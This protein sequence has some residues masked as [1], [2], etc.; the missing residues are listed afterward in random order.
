M[1]DGTESDIFPLKTALGYYLISIDTRSFESE[2]IPLRSSDLHLNVTGI[3]NATMGISLAAVPGES[4]LANGL[5]V[6]DITLTHPLAN[7][8]QFSGFDV[9]GI[10]MTKG[11][12]DVGP[13]KFAGTSDTRLLN[14]DG[15]TRWWNPAEFTSPGMFGY[16]QGNLSPTPASILTAT[17]NPYKY[18]A[19]ALSPT[20]TMSAVQ[21]APLDADNGRGIFSSGA[22]NTRRYQIQ[23]EMNPGPKVQFGYAIGASWLLPDPNPPNEVPDDFPINA[24]QPEAYNIAIADKANSLFYD[25]ESGI[26]GGVLRLQ[27]NVQDWQ[28]QQ[29]GNIAGQVEAVRL[30]SPD[31]Y[32]GGFNATFKEETSTKAVYTLDLNGTALPTHSG[33]TQIFVRAASLGGPN[34]QQGFGPAP[35]ANIDAWNVLTLNIPDPDCVA[36]TTDAFNEAITIGLDAPYIDQMCAPNDYR[37][38]YKFTIQ[39]GLIYDGTLTLYCDVEPTTFGIYDSDEQLIHE[40]MVSNGFAI[41]NFNDLNLFPELYYIRI[42]TNSNDIAFKYMLDPDF[43]ITDKYPDN[44]TNLA[45]SEIGMNPE[46]IRIYQDNMYVIGANQLWIY[47][48]S[49]PSDPVLVSSTIIDGYTVKPA[50]RYPNIYYFN[51][52]E[53]VTGEV[54]LIDV[55]DPANPVDY[56]S[57]FSLPYFANAFSMDEKYLYLVWYDTGSTKYHLDLYDYSIDPQNPEWQFAFIMDLYIAQTDSIKVGDERFLVLNTGEL[58]QTINI[59]DLDNIPPPDEFSWV[60]NFSTGMTVKDNFIFCT[61]EDINTTDDWLTILERKSQAQGLGTIT[62]YSLQPGDYQYIYVT[63]DTA[64]IPDITGHLNLY[65]ITDFQFPL[66]SGMLN[67]GD[68]VTSIAFSGSYMY[69]GYL[70]KGIEAIDFT[71]PLS[72]VSS[73]KITGIDSPVDA[74]YH[75]GYIYSLEWSYNSRMVKSFQVTAPDQI[76]YLDMINIQEDP[77]HMAVLDDKLIIGSWNNKTVLAVDISD[78]ANLNVVDSKTYGFNVGAIAIDEKYIYVSTAEDKVY[79]LQTSNW[80]VLDGNQYLANV[81]VAS[82][83]LID[84][85]VVY[86]STGSTLKVYNL[87]LGTIFFIED[88]EAM[89]YISN[90]TLNDDYMLLSTGNGLEVLDRTNPLNVDLLGSIDGPYAPIGYN[91]AADNQF[92][93]VTSNTPWSNLYLFQYLPPDNPTFIGPVLSDNLTHVSTK[94]FVM[95]EMLFDFNSSYG[96]LI[97]DL[98]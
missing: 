97:W 86:I 27:V 12:V 35:D 79:L 4:D 75:D 29:A 90:L 89:D 3:L 26:G 82:D 14:A 16:T 66:Y 2:I 95:D 41:M 8:P 53:N 38:F 11:S 37:D 46:D 62:T 77:T 48:I 94:L 78:P 61:F 74:L 10:L 54:G 30:F 96:L 81:P 71:T 21:N 69:A 25:S 64:V 76:E 83:I 44:F 60:G 65:D 45:Q 67:M 57:V 34:Y 80:P 92:A 6:A 7:K 39:P 24:N 13:L 93:F 73:K 87:D 20:S 32:D 88:Y 49:V 55:S 5:F 85:T 17:V 23:F 18:F 68:Y 43:V 70:L 59:S 42:L 47:D 36:D 19:D 91:I 63:G 15:Y 52:L 84:G 40:E 50:F 51:I 56:Q 98:Y 9:M 31:L 72:P 1:T 58:L 33:D 22:S 28:G